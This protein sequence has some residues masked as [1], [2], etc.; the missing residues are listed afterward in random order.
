MSTITTNQRRAYLAQAT[1]AARVLGARLRSV[2]PAEQAAL[3]ALAAKEAG[4][5]IDLTMVGEPN[6]WLDA[7]EVLAGQLR[8]DMYGKWEIGSGCHLQIVELPR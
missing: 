8:C 5:P 4:T 1:D 3:L 7:R 6:D 2:S